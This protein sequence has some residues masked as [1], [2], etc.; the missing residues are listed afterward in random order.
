MKKY[1]SLLL[2][3]VLVLLPLC[4]SAEITR[5]DEVFMRE[6]F[7]LARKAI[8]RG[9]DPF[10]AVLVKD[11]KIIMRAD[12]SVHTD[13][14][15]SR[16]AEINL[17]SAAIREYGAAG[18]KNSTLYS[19]CEPCVMC[20]GA[21]ELGEGLIVRVVYG[22]PGQRLVEMV[23]EGKALSDKS[24]F[25]WAAN[26]IKVEGPVLQAEAEEVI[27]EYLAFHHRR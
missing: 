14:D 22:L 15:F 5:Q 24:F 19:S 9:D 4:A 16:H 18:I 25:K 27:R 21:I 13:D 8:Q 17:M 10:G 12:N 1:A 3:L 6:C 7:A 23:G 20:S 2:A 26:R 11:G